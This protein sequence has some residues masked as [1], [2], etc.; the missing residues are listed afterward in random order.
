MLILGDSLSY[1]LSQYNI[2]IPHYFFTCLEGCVIFLIALCYAKNASL[3]FNTRQLRQLSIYIYL[4]QSIVI[5]LVDKYFNISCSILRFGIIAMIC[6]IV[7]MIII[8]LKNL[9]HN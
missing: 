9:F 7:A 2:I 5:T 1:W 6:C 8:N 4:E 3:Y